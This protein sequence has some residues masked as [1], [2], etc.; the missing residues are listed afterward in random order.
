MAAI[1]EAA[2]AVLRRSRSLAL[3]TATVFAVAAP[4]AHA[5]Q[6]EGPRWPGTTITYYA[7]AYRKATVLGAN[8][9]NNANVGVQFVRTSSK[10]AADLVVTYGAPQCEGESLVGYQGPFTQSWT[11]LGRGCDPNFMVLTATHEL[12]HILGLGHAK[13]RCAR[14]DSSVDLSGTP[15]HC[16][17]HSLSYW[18]KH[19]LLP[20]DIRGARKLYG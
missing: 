16:S 18:L 19:P 20:D 17:H 15:S 12:G 14:M 9:W 7:S 8:N 4:A 2:A 10:Q 6:L 5:Y 11:E 13:H 3:A 1:H